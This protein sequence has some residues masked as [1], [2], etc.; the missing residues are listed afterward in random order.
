MI[1]FSDV[2]NKKSISKG[3]HM[4]IN[5][6]SFLSYLILLNLADIQIQILNCLAFPKN[7]LLGNY[8][9]DSFAVAYYVF[10]NCNDFSSLF[11]FIKIL[12]FLEVNITAL[13]KLHQNK[14]RNSRLLFFSFFLNPFLNI[15]T[16]L[17]C[18]EDILFWGNTH[19]PIFHLKNL[20]I[21][22][23]KVLDYQVLYT[24]FTVLL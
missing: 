16:V 15:V 4:K 23:C 18:N 19:T 24:A 11:S 12:K 8:Y 3:T 10:D 14:Y 1:F 2:P 17:K 21:L 5:L 9:T 22:Q 20:N 7:E 6:S 13:Y